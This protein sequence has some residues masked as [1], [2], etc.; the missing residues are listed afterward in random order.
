MLFTRK[1]RG[2]VSVH[3]AAAGGEGEVRRDAR[4]ILLCI[5][6]PPPQLECTVL[7]GIA[8]PKSSCPPGTL[9][10]NRVSADVFRIR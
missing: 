10:G 4:T 6:E 2:I 1:E 9:L 5:S 8:S 3:P 7:G